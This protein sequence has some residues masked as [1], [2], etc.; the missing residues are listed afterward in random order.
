[1]HRARLLTPQA[2][3]KEKYGIPRGLAA[4]APTREPTPEVHVYTG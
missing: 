3:N 2:I 1:M 4:Q